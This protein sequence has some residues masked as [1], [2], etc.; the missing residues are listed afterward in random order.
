MHS[1]DHLSYGITQFYLPPDRGDSPD[2]TP[3]IRQYSLADRIIGRAFG[4]LCRLSVIC[5]LFV[6][7][8]L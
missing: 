6:I 5:R 7:F 8:V 3:G 1:G 4:T 2:F